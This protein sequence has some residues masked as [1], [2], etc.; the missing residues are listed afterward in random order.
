MEKLRYYPELLMSEIN[1]FINKIENSVSR[2]YFKRQLNKIIE[3]TQNDYIEGVKSKFA[4]QFKIAELQGMEEF[5]VL[6]EETNSFKEY[7]MFYSLNKDFLSLSYFDERGVPV[8]IYENA[9]SDVLSSQ[10]SLN[11]VFAVDFLK[12]LCKHITFDFDEI[13]FSN[14]SFNLSDHEFFLFYKNRASPD[15]SIKSEESNNRIRYRLNS[16]EVHY[17]KKTGDL[18][19]CGFYKST[20]EIVVYFNRENITTNEQHMRNSLI[21]NLFNLNQDTNS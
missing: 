20:G 11:I 12:T 18:I 16:W 5:I 7:V 17:D 2:N 10:T 6:T 19:Y 9:T 14:E 8:V 1:R 21:L 15:L 3:V 4:L 13:S